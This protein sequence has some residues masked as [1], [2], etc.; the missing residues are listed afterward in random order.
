MAI[1]I[2]VPRSQVHQLQEQLDAVTHWIRNH[3]PLRPSE[4]VRLYLTLSDTIDGTTAHAITTAL[5]DKK[6]VKLVVA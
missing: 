4:L 5:A 6:R 1:T 3:G 2:A